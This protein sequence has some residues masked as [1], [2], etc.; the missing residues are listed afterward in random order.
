[1]N[2]DDVLKGSKSR[3]VKLSSNLIWV[4]M[5]IPCGKHKT[6]DASGLFSM[7]GAVLCRPRQSD[8]S[9]CGAV[10]ILKW[11]AQPSWHLG[12]SDGLAWCSFC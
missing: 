2:L 6:S 3:F 7:A 4:M 9:H 5:M 11:L 12:M 1:M 10:L 8:H